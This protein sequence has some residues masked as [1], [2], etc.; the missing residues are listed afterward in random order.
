MTT[1]FPVRRTERLHAGR[2]SEAEAQYFVTLVTKG[3]RPWLAGAP[4]EA[5]V[6]DVLRCWHDEEENEVLPDHIHVL[7]RFGAKLSVGQ[8]VGRWKTEIRKGV[9]YVGAFQ[10]DFWEHRVRESEAVENYAL[11]IFLNPYRAGLLRAGEVWTGW[12]AP[13]PAIFQFTS[14]LAADGGPQREWVDWP[15]ERF[16]ALAHGE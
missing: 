7:F 4:A 2:V 13:R 8:T 5:T 16:A 9:G 6:L 3:R 15:A 10:R 12:W 1:Q 11:Y 14:A